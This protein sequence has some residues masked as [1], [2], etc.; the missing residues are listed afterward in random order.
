MLQDK[1]DA[2]KDRSLAKN[3]MPVNVHKENPKKSPT[4]PQKQ[5]QKIGYNSS[6]SIIKGTLI[7]SS[8]HC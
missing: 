2:F 8:Q 4:S 7:A 6:E 1:L 5:K 3:T